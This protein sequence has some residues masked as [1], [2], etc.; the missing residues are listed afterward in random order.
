MSVPL[1]QVV[2]AIE[3]LQVSKPGGS[4]ASNKKRAK[5]KQKKKAAAASGVPGTT[6]IRSTASVRPFQTTMARREYLAQVS[7]A[8]GK[9][10]LQGSIYL[11][12]FALPWL[13]G[14][15]QNF[16]KYRWNKLV[17]MYI[18]DVGTTK[19]GSIAVGLDLGMTEAKIGENLLGAGHVVRD[20]A[21]TR[22]K[23]MALTPSLVTPLWNGASLTVPSAVLQTRKWY[24]VPTEKTTSSFSDY[25]PGFLAYFVTGPAS[26]TVGDV[27][28]D[29]SIT[30]AG[31]REA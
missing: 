30:F 16:E 15:S 7:V 28:V 26:T 4:Q 21:Y 29:Y 11:S 24:D 10:D 14:V 5:R 1:K 31:T 19:D 13:K 6:V 9:T 25:A 17:I 3:N 22:A 12:P 8:A 23:V 2:K 27:W 18:P 20:A